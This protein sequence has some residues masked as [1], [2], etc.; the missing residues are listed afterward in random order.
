MGIFGLYKDRGDDSKKNEE[1]I[2][3]FISFLFMVFFFN[4]ISGIIEKYEMLSYCTKN[5]GEQ[6]IFGNCSFITFFSFRFFFII[7]EN[8]E[9]YELLLACTKRGKKQREKIKE[10]NDEELCKSIKILVLV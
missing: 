8:V 3:I 6:R 10:I 1:I 2:E 7:C 4:M 5:E 9:K